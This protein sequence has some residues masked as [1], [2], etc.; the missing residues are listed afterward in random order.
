L[1][2]GLRALV[3]LFEVVG[4]NYAAPDFTA[5]RALILPRQF[6]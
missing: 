6:G 2:H 5:A 3:E 1:Q 4:R